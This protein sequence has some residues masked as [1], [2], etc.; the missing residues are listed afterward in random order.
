MAGAGAAGSA[1]RRFAPPGLRGEDCPEMTPHV[2]GS[3][4]IALEVPDAEAAAAFY[5]EVF[6]LE[7]LREGEGQAFLWLG[8]HQLL[9]IFEVAQEHRDANRHFG[10]IVRDDDE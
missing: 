6:A 5:Q 3:N 7:R 10:I 1:G 9:A 2:Y 4:H 8:P